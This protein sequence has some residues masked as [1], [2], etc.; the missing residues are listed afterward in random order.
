MASSDPGTSSDHERASWASTSAELYT[1][2]PRC[3]TCNTQAIADSRNLIICIDGTSNQFGQNNTN[4]VKLFAQVDLETRKPHPKQCAYY[5]SGIGT[6]PK[7]MHVLDR[8]ERAVSDK[9]DMAIAWNM[10]EIVKDAYGWLARTYLEGDQI[11]LFGFSRGAYQV[12]VLAGMIHEIGLIR[13]PTEK[14]IGTA[15]DH[16]ES[17]R[18]QKPKTREIA[19]EFKQTFSWKDLRVHF[20]G[21]WDTVSSVGLVRGDVFLST[22]S[23]AAHACHFRHA[24]AL[25]ERRVKFI[26]EYFHEMNTRTD[27]TKPKDTQTS[28][29]SEIKE[30][31]FAGS[32]SDVGGKNRPGK[33]SQAGNV[34]LLWMRQEA[35][36]SG[37]ILKPTDIVWMPD[38]LDSG[39][40]NSMSSAWKLV[41][42]LPIRHQVSFS[43]SGE[44]ARRWHLF[45]PR[46]IIPGQKIHASILYA[47]AYR[48]SAT[49]GDGFEVTPPQTQSTVTDLPDDRWEKGL[50]DHTAARV[51]V[52]H[53]SGQQGVAPIYL[54]RLL[55]M[56][57]FLP[58]G[59]QRFCQAGAWMEENIRGSR[60]QRKWPR[61]ARCP[62]C[63]LRS[64]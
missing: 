44:N 14:Q 4:V 17:I 1:P 11:Y 31:W 40:S 33:S 21:V 59:R 53:L 51:L 26:P 2:G 62:R 45:R 22:S 30:V 41:E 35:S 23:S 55:F 58:S 54:D 13:T 38:D 61:E 12:R 28:K 49:W 8:I 10:E 39:T 60:S 43:G 48:P 15:Y 9:F 52:G 57:R 50:F 6:R 27:D 25:D 19:R 47:N 36:S 29:A 18:S 37:L 64:L 5:S 56:L 3:S 42:I 63:L 7:S 16:Y 24:L 34:S 32:H 46:R 20:V